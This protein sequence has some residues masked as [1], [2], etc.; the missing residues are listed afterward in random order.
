MTPIDGFVI[1]VPENKI[2][3]YR[4]IELKAGEEPQ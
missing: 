2:D 4:R 3:D 1:P